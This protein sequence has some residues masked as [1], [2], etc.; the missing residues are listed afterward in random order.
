MGAD[1][2]IAGVPYWN[3][4]AYTVTEDATPLDPN[5]LNGG[6]GQI[7]FAIPERA[8]AKRLRNRVVNLSHET[9][10]VTSG[11][12]VALSGNG[13]A[14]TVTA[15]TPLNRLNVTRQAQPYVGTMGGA[16]RYYFGLCGITSDY[17]IDPSI[18]PIPVKLLG[19]KANV[20]DQVKKLCAAKR[21]E[22]PFAS[23]VIVV[24]RPRTITAYSERDSQL[25]WSVDET[26]LAASVTG[27]YYVTSASGTAN[28]LA[29]PPGGWNV[30]VQEISIDA[31]D[32]QEF[33]FDINASLSSVQQPVCVSSVAQGYGSSSV[34]TV[35]SGVDGL[36]IQPAQWAALG[37]KVSVV[38]GEDTRSLI[39]TVIAPT[40]PKYSPY[41]LV[42]PSGT[43]DGYSSLRIVGQGVF[44]DKRT[45]TLPACT[46]P[47]AVTEDSGADIDLE[48]LNTDEEAFWGVMRAA[49]HVA[50]PRQKIQVTSNGINRRG[51]KNSYV[52][53]TVGDFIEE[54][55]SHGETISNF[56]ALW[57]GKTVGDFS[58]AWR[59]RTKDDFANQAFGNVA[60]ARVENNGCWYRIRN[61]TITPGSIQYTAESDT[62]VGDVKRA[63]AGKTVGDLKEFWAG[64]F[65]GD[66]DLAPT[67][68]GSA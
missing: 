51:K 47:D 65:V 8:T 49:Q 63:W 7:T 39:V 15:N 35:A 24:R 13:I 21:I 2:R 66:F 17:S 56:K 61:A 27:T 25:S 9:R 53:S 41:R 62:T 22:V 37:G 14:V 64:S 32:T 48:F 43:S 10:G 38:I 3:A 26:Q 60:G 45:L 11:T 58:T 16:L 23:D 57:A 28:W 67:S 40:E 34:Y 30:D 68:V 44:F 5:D 59:T 12:T 19:W 18:D 52:Y 29:Y 4:S 55:G 36:L 42:M 6:V 46:R 20:W 31:G 54:Y 33:T 1:I 50:G